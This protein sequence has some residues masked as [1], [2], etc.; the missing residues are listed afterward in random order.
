MTSAYVTHGSAATFAADVLAQSHER[1]VLV[2]F[3]ADWCAPCR[4]LA[5]VLDELATRHCGGLKVVKIDSDAE[6]ALGAQYAVR[7]LPTLLL[8]RDGAVAQ[9]VVGAQPLAALERLIEPYLVRPTD[10]LLAEAHAAH[11]LGNVA[12]A[13]AHLEAA[14]ALD[15]RDFRVHPALAGLYLELGRNDDARALLTLLPANLSVADA[16][17][18]IKA[19]LSL[20]DAAIVVAGDDEVSCGYRD[21]VAAAVA[22]DFD[23][24]VDGLLDLLMRAR[25]WHG[26]AVRKTLLDIFSVLGADPRLK[27]WRTRMARTLN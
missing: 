9:Q 12:Q 14:L 25:D 6:P 11:A 17:Q 21:A 3:W 1:P 18:P 27:A 2:D 26:G 7:S 24:A 16:V 13:V 19:R 10:T 15:A 4:A 23:T 20:A 22:G 5:P 8:F